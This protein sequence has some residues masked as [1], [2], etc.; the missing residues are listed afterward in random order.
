[1]ILCS[2]CVCVCNY[3]PGH[4]SFQ[5]PT[6]RAWVLTRRGIHSLHFGHWTNLEPSSSEEAAETE[7]TSNRKT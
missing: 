2:V 7:N 5:S 4:C 3:L 6:L 1:M